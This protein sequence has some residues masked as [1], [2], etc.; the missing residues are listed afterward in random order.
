MP[1]PSYPSDTVTLQ[2][3]GQNLTGW[4][5][6]RIVRGIEL[7]PS[8][9]SLRL[10]E[11]L[12]GAPMSLAIDPGQTCK[13]MVG[14]DL[15]MTGYIDSYESRISAKGHEITVVG[16]SG[17]QDLVD[18]AA[19]VTSGEELQSRMTF[20]APT[21]L[22]L[23]TDLCAPFGITVTEPDG[24]GAPLISLMDGIPQFTMQLGETVYDRLESL[25][26]ARQMLLVDGEDGNLILAKIG[27][28]KA[29]SGF[30]LP[31]NVIEAGVRFSKQDRFTIYLPAFHTT[32]SAAEVSQGLGKTSSN[33]Q[34]PVEDLAAFKGQP[35]H[36][37]SDRYRP[38]FV[39]SDQMI[40]GIE[41]AEKL[42]KW[43]LARRFG[44]SQAITVL[45]A[46]WRDA[47]GM[48]WTPNTLAQVN[49]PALKV[50][51]RTWLISQVAYLKGQAGTQTQVTL[52]PPE[53]FQ[54][55]P[56]FN[57]PFDPQIAQALQDALKASPQDRSSPN[58][59]PRAGDTA[60][61]V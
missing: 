38:H 20:S 23:A 49:M 5:D 37:G 13:V 48:L 3:G 52:M 35:R 47:S 6:V 58:F 40:D 51:G 27:T 24:E 33:F 22:S 8:F 17:T 57:M 4:Q 61:G 18:C 50:A 26:Q 45:V 54:P 15:V 7:F 2:V 29:A 25:A 14:A 21:L 41:L 43:E 31:G 32:D 30:T 39:V 55:E 34:K 60:G 28:K 19:G 42:A 12:P 10:T 59:N 46:L 56:T 44:R 11:R 9:F 36:D 1:A 16:R 53:A